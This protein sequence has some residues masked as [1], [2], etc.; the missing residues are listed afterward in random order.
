MKRDAVD[1]PN[2]FGHAPGTLLDRLYRLHGAGHGL[3]PCIGRLAH[4]GGAH[5]CALGCLC[6]VLHGGRQLLHAGGSFFQVRRLL[7][8]AVCKR[9]VALG[10]TLPC[11]GDQGRIAADIGHHGRQRQHH[12]VERTGQLADFVAAVDTRTGTQ[13]ASGGEIHGTRQSRQV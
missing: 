12:A 4:G 5:V 6:I 10:Q 1:D 9:P 7:L 8:G 2:D 11:M 13:I 3:R